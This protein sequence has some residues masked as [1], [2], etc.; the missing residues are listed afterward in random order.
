MQGNKSKHPGPWTKR[1]DLL[2]DNT[3]FHTT[4]AKRD[5]P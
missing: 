1:D 5:T 3:H 4:H 2:Y